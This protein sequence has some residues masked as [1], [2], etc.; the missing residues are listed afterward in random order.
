MDF[1]WHLCHNSGGLTERRDRG[2]NFL[3]PLPLFRFLLMSHMLRWR[4]SPYLPRIEGEKTP[5]L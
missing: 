1:A 3:I 4:S 5:T 2:G